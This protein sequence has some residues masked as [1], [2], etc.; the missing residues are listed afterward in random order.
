MNGTKLIGMASITNPGQEQ[1][2]ELNVNELQAKNELENASK[3]AIEDQG[4]IGMSGK[5]EDKN[6]AGCWVKSD[7]VLP[8]IGK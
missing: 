6:V 7:N 8:R 3:Q 1:D 5:L 2:N 4:E